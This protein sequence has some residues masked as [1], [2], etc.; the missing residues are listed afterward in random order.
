MPRKKKAKLK[1][2][3]KKGKNAKK[4]LQSLSLSFYDVDGEV[5][6]FER[7]CDEMF[8]YVN[9]ELRNRQVQIKSIN[10][11][12]GWIV[13]T[14]QKMKAETIGTTTQ[15]VVEM[16]PSEKNSLITK[17]EKIRFWHG[18]LIIN[19]VV[20][21]LGL[22]GI[23]TKCDGIKQIYQ[24]TS[25]TGVQY[26]I[27][28]RDIQT[29]FE[30]LYCIYDFNCKRLPNFYPSIEFQET[31]NKGTGVLSKKAMGNG[32]MILKDHCCL[33]LQIEKETV[34]IISNLFHIL[35]QQR[36]HAWDFIL[37]TITDSGEEFFK[38]FES[39][40]SS[41]Q[42]ALASKIE[43]YQDEKYVKLFTRMVAILVG[44]TFDVEVHGKMMYVLF[45][46]ISAFNHSCAPNCN[47]S[48]G[49]DKNGWFG[50]IK[51]TKRIPEGQ[52]LTINYLPG[53]INSSMPVEERRQILQE[54]R[55]FVCICDLCL[56]QSNG[57][58]VAEN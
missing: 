45:P 52:P 6:R 4:K 31:E 16:K 56:E 10:Q 24:F 25:N 54:K 50:C 18:P 22:T 48:M 26:D 27:L 58:Q 32:D 43:L 5:I 57:E 14:G 35:F 15:T 39:H 47:M 12:K 11:K 9:N 3:S 19:S 30:L 13:L 7:I 49:T 20:Q 38:R 36:K 29:K 44:N 40:G 34:H 28:F 42:K 51:T 17:L 8:L 37:N 55:N 21:C 41:I 2:K 46:H 53:Q 23:I 1:K 33:T